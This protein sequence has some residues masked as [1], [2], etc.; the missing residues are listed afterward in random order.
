MSGFGFLGL[1][2]SWGVCFLPDEETEPGRGGKNKSSSVINP[3]VL[4]LDAPS[5][6]QVSA[7]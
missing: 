3:E 1:L 6:M 2:C 4:P 5:S 7:Y